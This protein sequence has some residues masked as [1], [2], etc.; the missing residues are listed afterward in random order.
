MWSLANYPMERPP[1]AH[2]SLAR[3]ST[4]P[5]EDHVHTHANTTPRIDGL[6]L[7]PR[8]PMAQIGSAYPRRTRQPSLSYLR[9]A[10]EPIRPAHRHPTSCPINRACSPRTAFNPHTF[11]A[12]AAYCKSPYPHCSAPTASEHEKLSPRSTADTALEIWHQLKPQ[13]WILQGEVA[14][15]SSSEP[16]GQRVVSQNTVLRKRV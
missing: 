3:T 13:P 8:H 16:G 12:L 15:N 4:R 9:R 5:E 11:T 2:R 10:P 1:P 7:R 14:K 6:S